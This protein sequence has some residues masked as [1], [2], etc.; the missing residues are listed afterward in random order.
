MLSAIELRAAFAARELSPVETIDDVTRREELGAFV[1]LDL[2]RARSEAKAAEQANA[3]GDARPLGGLPRR[4]KDLLH[5]GGRRPACGSSIFARRVP[6]ADAWAVRGARDAG[7][8]V[9]G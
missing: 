8:I 9:L 3:R 7:A 5:T 6:A 1:T 4:G 2:E